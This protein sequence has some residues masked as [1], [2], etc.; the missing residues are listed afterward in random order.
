MAQKRHYHFRRKGWSI[1]GKYWAN[2]RLKSGTANAESSRSSVWGFHFKGVSILCPSSCAAR[3]VCPFLGLVLLPVYS[4]PW[5]YF[6]AL[7]SPI[8]WSLHCGQPLLS[9]LYEIAS[10]SRL[11]SP[12][13]PTT[14]CLSSVALKL[15]EGSFP[16]G[17][18]MPLKPVPHG[19]P[20]LGQHSSAAKA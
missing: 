14:H 9:Q 10:H 15:E 18:F 5:Q 3:G 6:M 7:V 2:T 13:F 20:Y 16:L 19:Q 8:S 11:L 12:G 1:I 17:S 4:F